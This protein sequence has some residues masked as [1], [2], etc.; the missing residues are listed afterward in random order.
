MQ[1]MQVWA[2]TESAWLGIKLHPRK[3]VYIGRYY[4]NSGGSFRKTLSSCM[5][6]THLLSTKEKNWEKRVLLL[7]FNQLFVDILFLVM[8]NSIFW[9]EFYSV[10]QERSLITKMLKCKMSLSINS[11]VSTT[12][13]MLCVRV[14]VCVCAAT[15]VGDLRE[16]CWNWTLLCDHRLICIPIV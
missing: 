7:R 11:A 3:A 9:Q 16:S 4:L 2:E 6:N 15:A 13:Y 5:W 1:L 8:Q 12:I 10:I 14:C